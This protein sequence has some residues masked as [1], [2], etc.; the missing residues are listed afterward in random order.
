MLVLVALF[1]LAPGLTLSLFAVM[2][3]Y[4]AEDDPVEQGFIVDD[5]FFPRSDTRHPAAFVSGFFGEEYTLDT[6][7]FVN[8]S[9]PEFISRSKSYPIKKG[10][11]FINLGQYRDPWCDNTL[12]EI[13]SKCKHCDRIYVGLCDQIEVPESDWE[14]REHECQSRDADRFCHG[15][16]DRRKQIRVVHL[17]PNEAAGPTWARYLSSKLFRGEEYFFQ[18]DAHTHF[19]PHWDVEIDKMLARLP[20]KK[21]L[22]SNYPVAMEKEIDSP[23]TP[24]ICSGKFKP[25]L[26]GMIELV[27]NWY[28]IGQHNNQLQRAPFIGAGFIVGPATLLYDAPY[29][30]YLPYMF[31]GEEF[32][33]ASRLWTSGWDFYVPPRNIISHIYGHRNQS[34]FKDTPQWWLPAE[35]SRM[36]A[37]H[38]IGYPH[39]DDTTPDLTEIEHLGLGN[40]RTMEEYQHFAGMDIATQ[41]YTHPRCLQ[42]YDEEQNQWYDDPLRVSK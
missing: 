2:P 1:L 16:K 14:C 5:S 15:P 27:A 34:V 19:M 12:N 7:P 4:P 30:R 36:R 9:V 42:L 33:M 13:F 17:Y 22:F 6:Y 32:L 20:H 24:W 10:A 8:E 37:R 25:H 26:K 18:I 35:S 40:E 23:G 29:D 41:N 3:R 31:H 38:I 11:I 39:P 21:S 28:W